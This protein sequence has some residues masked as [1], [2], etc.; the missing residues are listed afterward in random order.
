MNDEKL[1]AKIK[2]EIFD[3]SKERFA[4]SATSGFKE[5]LESLL[6][7][8][9][10]IPISKLF[11]K[12]WKHPHGRDI[13]FREL[14]PNL[15]NKEFKAVR[16][17]EKQVKGLYIWFSNG[18][19]FYVGI[20]RKIAKRLHQHINNQS[21]YSASMAYKIA[22]LV[23]GFVFDDDV[24][25]DGKETR[26]KFSK[27]RIKKIQKWLKKQEVSY[28][29]VTNNDELALFE[30]FCSLELKTKLNSFETT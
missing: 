26:A 3:D 10:R 22:Y 23:F 1:D 16:A 21:H 17:K 25:D 14:H 20:S 4:F 8:E 28:V 6:R 9:N 5:K 15:T 2:S 7:E 12:D 24:E 27:K 19:P 11:G 29:P 13:I 18:K 30:I